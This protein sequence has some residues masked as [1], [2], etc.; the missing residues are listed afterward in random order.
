MVICGGIGCNNDSRNK[1]IGEVQGWHVVPYKNEENL[2]CDKWIQAMKREPPYPVNPQNFDLCL[3]FTD[4]SFKRDLR[5]EMF[6]GTQTFNLVDGSVP[7][8]FSF[9]MLIVRKCLGETQTKIYSSMCL[10]LGHA[11]PLVPKK[12][13]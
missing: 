10:R 5:F 4:D 8:I 2:L 6:G 1:K 11:F 13:V 12:V 7:S 9:S 3:H